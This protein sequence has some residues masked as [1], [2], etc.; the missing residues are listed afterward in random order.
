MKIRFN[1]TGAKR[2]ELAQAVAEI[3]GE[4]Y[5]YLG[6]PTFA[7]A[8]DYFTIDR[9]GTLIF[10]DR[11]DEGKIGEL[12]SGLA[13]R[14]FDAHITIVQSQEE[15]AA[16]PQ[17]VSEEEEVATPQ[18]EAEEE[19]QTAESEEEGSGPKMAEDDTF[20]LTISMPWEGFDDAAWQNLKNLVTSKEGLI[21]K[22]LGIDALPMM[23]TPEKISFPWFETQPDADVAKAAMELI[24]ALCRTAKTQKRV[25]AKEREVANEKYAFR[26]FLLRLGFIGA[27]YKETRKTLLR[28]LSGN[29][30]FRDGKKKEAAGDAVSE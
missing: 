26:C 23:F 29:G 16:N 18:Q 2:K 13:E 3:L 10:D 21:K 15:E 17:Q 4:D 28:N 25:T 19:Q 5:R 9:E 1:V 22:A 12:I 11:T 6:V 30:A 20:G 7:Y 14:D 24:A 27:E 8:F